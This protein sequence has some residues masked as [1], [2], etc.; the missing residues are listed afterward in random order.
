MWGK[1]AA[2]PQVSASTLPVSQVQNRGPWFRLSRST[3]W[4]RLQWLSTQ[5]TPIFQNTATDPST[6]R[7]KNVF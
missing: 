3:S 2:L 7:E 1:D 5:R 6:P 4:C